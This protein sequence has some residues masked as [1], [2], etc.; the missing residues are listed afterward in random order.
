MHKTKQKVREFFNRIVF[1]QSKIKDFLA[2]RESKVDVLMNYWEK[3][4]FG[5][6][7][8]AAPNTAI[9]KQLDFNA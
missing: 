3:L 8:N 6:I 5:I 1:M 9:G 7:N 4:E 2:C